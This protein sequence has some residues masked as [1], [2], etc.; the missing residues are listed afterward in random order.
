MIVGFHFVSRSNASANHRPLTG[1]TNA[2]PLPPPFLVQFQSF[3]G[4]FL[5]G[6]MPHNRFQI[7]RVRQQCVSQGTLPQ[8]NRSKSTQSYFSGKFTKCVSSASGHLTAVFPIFFRR[9]FHKKSL[10]FFANMRS[11][12]QNLVLAFFFAAKL[13]PS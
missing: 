6:K 7:Q 11:D 13:T 2:L 5:E 12:T 9:V 1:P 3:V 4:I 8:K 10:L